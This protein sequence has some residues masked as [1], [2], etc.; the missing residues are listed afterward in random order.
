MGLGKADGTL[1]EPHF[2]GKRVPVYELTLRPV[3][4]AL[5]QGPGQLRAPSALRAWDKTDPFP[6][7]SSWTQ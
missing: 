3:R 1:A 7:V 5:P 6:P 4:G 2:T